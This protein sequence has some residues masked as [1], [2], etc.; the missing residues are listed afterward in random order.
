MILIFHLHLNRLFNNVNEM[1][2]AI[3]KNHNELI[4]NEDDF[5]FLGDFSFAKLDITI[6]LMSRLNGNKFFIGGN[7]DKKDTI[8]VYKKFGT[9][10][11]GLAEIEVNKQKIVLCHY[12]MRV[13]N[14]SHRGTWCLYGHSHHS[15]P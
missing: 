9:Y 8:E 5:Y 10:L 15:L 6:W 3:I 4:S 13:W 2:E 14:G 12:A 11:G 1:N 7:H